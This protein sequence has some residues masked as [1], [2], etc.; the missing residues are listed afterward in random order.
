MSRPRRD[1]K[2]YSNKS[3]AELAKLNNCTEAAIR[4]YIHKNGIDRRYE[5]VAKVI[6]ECRKL[7][8]RHAKSITS[9]GSF[10]KAWEGDG[11]FCRSHKQIPSLSTVKRYWE[12]ISTDKPY[13]KVNQSKLDKPVLV[14]TPDANRKQLMSE[15]LLE[16]P[17]IL[18]KAME[19][20]VSSLSRFL[21]QSPERPLLAIGSGG[22]SSSYLTM[23]YSMN[24]GLGMSL[25]PYMLPSISD[26]TMQGSKVLLLSKSGKNDDIKYA[27]QRAL[28]AKTEWIG[29]YTAEAN[30]DNEMVKLLKE[31]NARV[32]EFPYSDAEDGFISLRGKFHKY[33]IFYKVF[34]QSEMPIQFSHEPEKCFTY[35][36]NK[37]GTKLPALN[38]V[39]TFSVLY[40]GWGEPVARDLESMSNECGLAAVTTSDYRN[41]CHGRFIFTSNHVRNY[42]E[43]R[44]ESDAA[45][46]LLITPREKSIAS[47]MMESLFPSQ[48]PLVIIETEYDSPLA[49]IDLL[50]KANVFFSYVAE[51]CYGINPNSPKNYSDIDKTFPINGIKFLNNLKRYGIQTYDD[52]FKEAAELKAQIDIL[53]EDEHIN[54]SNIQKASY[55]LWHPSK[56]DL[57]KDEKEQY[58]ASKYLCYA[59]RRS[60]DK[61]KDTLIPFGNMNKGFPFKLEGITIQTS[62]SAYICG[63]F[64]DNTP[65]HIAIQKELIPNTNGYAAK[66]ETRGNNEHLGRADWESYNVEW[67]L[68]C[69]W[70]KVT[71]NKNFRELLLSIPKDCVIIE[72]SSFQKTMRPVDKPAFWGCRN[73]TQKAFGKLA[74]KYADAMRPSTEKE[75]KE[76]AAAL[77]DDFCNAGTYIGHNTM[78]KILMIVRNC[79][80][81]GIEPEIDYELLRSKHIHLLG[82]EMQYR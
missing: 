20:D 60:F 25:T 6:E 52:N 81:E 34:C 50:Y 7:Y 17:S 30:D 71:G 73:E 78:G 53:L 47:Q 57:Y 54:T 24:K 12:Y 1:I 44:E 33:G 40:G 59:F 38:K 42:K 49:T 26:S 61:H 41:Y 19:A 10:I 64:S 82:K 36:L 70:N 28:E 5:N 72:N 27:T 3:V 48:T 11:Y 67:M 80:Y 77:T 43:P 32:F 65:E 4:Y 13:D 37:E 56:A 74:D 18:Q 55:K 76:I 8:K 15:I 22:A 39:S 31:S 35:K 62:E 16:V 79:L 9:P 51:K 14:E 45:I 75:G 23:L 2:L 21:L 69:V 58:D 63:L 66:K 68:Y 46:V 29:A